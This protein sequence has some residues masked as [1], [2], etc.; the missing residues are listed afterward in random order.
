VERAE[1]LIRRCVEADVKLVVDFELRYQPSLQQLKVAIEA[2]ELGEMIH[3]EA[4][5]KW[6]RSQ[7]YYDRGGWRGTWRMD[8][9]GSLANQGVHLVDALIWLC[10]MPKV[11]GARSGV[12]CHGIESEDATSALLELPRSAIGSLITMTCC[13]RN[14]TFGLN[15]TGTLA[16]VVC[17]SRGIDVTFADRNRTHLETSRPDWPLSAVEDMVRS[18]REGRELFVDG[19]QGLASL[20]LIES[21]YAAAGIRP[22]GIPYVE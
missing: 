9:G 17:T 3:A 21:I 18:L 15:L 11:V 22:I 4:R 8:G 14:D 1:E 5:C 13:H 2:G 10:G 7:E 19:R 6:W 20:H 16:S 12:F